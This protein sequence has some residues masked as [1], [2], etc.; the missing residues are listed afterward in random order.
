MAKEKEKGFLKDN[1]SLILFWVIVIGLSLGAYLVIS[2]FF[3][4]PENEFFTGS[5]QVKDNLSLF[6][7]AIIGAV[8]SFF[9]FWVDK[10][11]KEQG[12]RMREMNENQKETNEELV[13][14]KE[15]IKKLAGIYSVRT[16]MYNLYDVFSGK[17]HKIEPNEA[18]RMKFV[19]QLND[20]IKEEKIDETN[21]VYKIWS[22]ARDE[23]IPAFPHNKD[24]CSKCKELLEDQQ[25]HYREIFQHQS[26]CPQC[27][28]LKGLIEEYLS[29]NPNP[30]Q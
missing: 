4:P 19:N 13:Q 26:T 1:K 15:G 6:V 17:A 18:S 5:C 11:Q 10:K 7:G 14:V 3:C 2:Y 23:K 25:K 20:Y 9:F 22:K 28:D 16:C 8:T 29:K 30:G 27:K 21:D 12:K 24:E